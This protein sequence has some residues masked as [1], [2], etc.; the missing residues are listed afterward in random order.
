MRLRRVRHA[1]RRAW[2]AEEAGARNWREGRRYSKLWR[3]KQLE[4]TWLR[5]LM[6]VHAD[7]W[8]VTGEALDYA[9]DVYEVKEPGL[10]DELMALYLKL[11]AFPE[12]KEALEAVKGRASSPPFFQ[13]AALRCLMPRCA[14]PGWTSCSTSCFRSKMSAS[15]SR[16]GECT[17]T[18]CRSCRSTMHLRVLRLSEYVD[19]QGAAHFGFQA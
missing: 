4:Y 19:A 9:L 1:L 5:S 17:A 6:G 2:A 15:T 3:Q 18:R 11:D 16:A 7:F 14:T 10:K 12:V 8:H 13:T